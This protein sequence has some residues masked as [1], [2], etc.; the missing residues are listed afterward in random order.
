MEHCKANKK[1]SIVPPNNFT[2]VARSKGCYD[3]S[4]IPTIHTFIPHHLLP[5]TIL[6]DANM[7]TNYST[8]QLSNIGKK[9]SPRKKNSN[10]SAPGEPVPAENADEDFTPSPEDTFHDNP[11]NVNIGQLCQD[12]V[13]LIE[14]GHIVAKNL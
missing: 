14:N 6:G 10:T 9:N 1:G 3:P 12:H 2:F 8:P 13:T 7:V 5:S 4:H 11:H